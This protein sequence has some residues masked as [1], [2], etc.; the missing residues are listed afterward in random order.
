MSSRFFFQSNNTQKQKKRIQNKKRQNRK[1]WI[2]LNF[3]VPCSYYFQ[4]KSKR[5]RPLALFLINMNKIKCKF[6]WT[7]KIFDLFDSIQTQNKTKIDIEKCVCR[8]QHQTDRQYVSQRIINLRTDRIA[9]NN[10]RKCLNNWEMSIPTG[11]NK[12]HTIPYSGTG[13]TRLN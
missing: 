11:G 9:S 3:L 8:H 5:F 6:Y 4:I 2:N 1:N 7:P 13:S 12:N 10:C